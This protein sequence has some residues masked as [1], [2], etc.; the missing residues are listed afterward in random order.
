[1]EYERELISAG[2]MFSH[3]PALPAANSFA[4]CGVNPEF[5]ADSHSRPSG[6]DD[7]FCPHPAQ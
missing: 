3:L 7:R 6:T 4:N 2:H 1:M 5:L